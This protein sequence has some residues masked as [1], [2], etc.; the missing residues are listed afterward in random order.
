[1]LNQLWSSVCQDPPLAWAAVFVLAA[2]GA[3]AHVC[4]RVWLDGRRAGAT[5]AAALRQDTHT[6]ERR[7]RVR[8]LQ[9]RFGTRRT[10]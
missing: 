3:L 1:M 5:T 6:A 9:G 10:S 8:L 4:V 7:R 2:V